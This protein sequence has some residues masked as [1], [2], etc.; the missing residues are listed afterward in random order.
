M[1]A[2]SSKS[3]S[4]YA[5][6]A[7]WSVKAQELLDTIISDVKTGWASNFCEGNNINAELCWTNR[8][9][10]DN[11]EEGVKVILKWVVGK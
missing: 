6:I 11:L 2:W 7:W 4:Q 1:N 8:F 3:T 9:E 10:S 5:F